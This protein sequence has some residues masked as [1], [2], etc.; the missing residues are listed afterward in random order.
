MSSDAK[1]NKGM[2][3]VRLTLL[4]IIFSLLK[5]RTLGVRGTDQTACPIE[6][7]AVNGPKGA[8]A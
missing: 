1:R 4:L 5:V 6:S 3:R 7:R 8:G 2:A